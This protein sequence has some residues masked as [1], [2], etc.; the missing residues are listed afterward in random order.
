MIWR[1]GLGKS[2]S[3]GAAEDRLKQQT[4]GEA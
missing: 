3:D 2:Q 1:V 4:A